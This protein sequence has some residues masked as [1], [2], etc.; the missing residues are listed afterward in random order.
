MILRESHPTQHAEGGILQRAIRRAAETTGNA[1]LLG[2]AVVAA[3]LSFVEVLND[4]DEYLAVPF[5][6]DEV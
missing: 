4:F 5:D 6:N 1:V 3:S 2:A